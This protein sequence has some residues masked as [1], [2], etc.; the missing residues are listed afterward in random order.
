[1]RRGG[2]V[3][4]SAGCP[5]ASFD[6]MKSIEERLTR[7]KNMGPEMLGNFYDDELK[8]FAV[9]PGTTSRFS[10]TSTCFALQAILSG[11]EA[12]A[13]TI[14]TSTNSSLRETG[15]IPLVDVLR[16]LASAEWRV[17]DLFQVPMVLITLLRFDATG[18]L[19]STVESEK[20]SAAI[21]SLLESRSRRRYGR[22]Q[23]NS[24]YTQFWLVR[25]MLELLAPPG[26]VSDGNR[27][28]FE[29][30]GREGA[31]ISSKIPEAVRTQHSSRKLSVAL[32]RA[33]V[34]VFFQ[35]IADTFVYH[36]HPGVPLATLLLTTG[37]E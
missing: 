12:W 1:M 37:N 8:S 22:S 32:T 23:P 35:R 18:D 13:G 15:Q 20:L 5:D 26:R 16:E 34:S 6:R 17:D 36:P 30:N 29:L 11:P 10:V 14:F 21:S 28:Y 31:G 33:A 25:A 19:I 7:V 3:V 24:A 27:F 4:C 9:V 2:G